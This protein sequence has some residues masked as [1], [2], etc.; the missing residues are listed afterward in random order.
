MDETERA[1]RDAQQEHWTKTFATDA[2]AF[3]HTSDFARDT[4]VR[5]EVEGV[6]DLL[7]LGAGQGRD[8]IVFAQAGL[9]VTAL[10][11]APGALAQLEARAR[12][13]GVADLVATRVADV[14]RPL[15][16][17]DAAFD[18]CYAHLLF[19]MALTTGELEAL[20]AEVRRVLRPGGVLSYSVRSTSDKHYRVGID[21]GD[22]MWE[23]GNGYIVHFFGRK[24][25]DRL[26]KGFEL[27]SVREYQEFALPIHVFGVTMRKPLGDRSRS[28]RASP[29]ASRSSRASPRA[30]R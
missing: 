9:R 29:R 16:V 12:A 11:Y 28:S 14:R 27:V 2:D 6:R 25:V 19:N 5:F 15:P 22:D 18:A 1:A 23:A 13:L 20:V 30:S 8:T 21:H 4:L 7:E 24:L 17:R 26:A 10:D 3:G